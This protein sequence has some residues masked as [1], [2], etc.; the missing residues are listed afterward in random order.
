[1]AMTGKTKQNKPKQVPK[2]ENMFI[3]TEW[4]NKL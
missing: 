3:N 2:P 4:I 1:M